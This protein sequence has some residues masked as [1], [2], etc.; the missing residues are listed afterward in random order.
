MSYP[1]AI[2]KYNDK[3]SM[4][5][6]ANYFFMHIKPNYKDDVGLHVH[7]YGHVKQ[8]WAWMVVFAL[9]AVAS[10]CY[11]PSLPLALAIAFQGIFAHNV[12]YSIVRPYAKWCEVSCYRK[13]VGCYP[14]GTSIEFAIRALMDKY[15][16]KM[17][18]EEAERALQ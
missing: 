7:E 11:V 5:G 6:E 8:W 13:Q 3:P 14:K 2:V 10:Y 15:K 16:F 4:A 17:T 18:R 9:L 12:L 1:F